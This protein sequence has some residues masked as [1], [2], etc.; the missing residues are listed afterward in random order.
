VV[1]VIIVVVASSVSTVIVVAR[2]V[3][4]VVVDTLSS[5]SGFD[6]VPGVAVG[7]ETTLDRRCRGS[8]SLPVLSMLG[9]KRIR[10]VL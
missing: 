7:P 6:G 8:D 10:T 5:S 4:A 2:A 1:A 3:V 9:R